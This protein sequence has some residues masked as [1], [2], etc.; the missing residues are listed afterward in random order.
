MKR[1]AAFLRSIVPADPAQLIF[2]AGVVLLFVS[3]RVSWWPSKLLHSSDFVVQTANRKS[4]LFELRQ[5]ITFALLPVTFAGVVGYFLCLWPAKK[6]V[7]LILWAL[8]LPSVFG[9]S[10]VMWKTFAIT[11]EFTSVLD[12]RGGF[13]GLLSWFH[14]NAGRFPAGPIIA[15]GGLLLILVFVVRLAQGTSSLPLVLPTSDPTSSQESEV[16]S[17]VRLLVF[18]LIGPYFLLSGWMALGLFLVVQRTSSSLAM[19][20]I[21]HS[22][23]VFEAALLIYLSLLVMG[24]LGRTS[25]RTAFQIPKRADIAVAVLLPV[26]ASCMVPAAHYVIDRVEWAAH[27][28]GKFLP[29]PQ[30]SLYFNPSDAWE[31]WLLLMV[32]A[33][34]AEELIF[35]GI[36]LRSFIDRYGLHRGIF[37][38]GMAWA[39][40]HF[41]SDTYAGL[42]PGG[43]GSP[44]E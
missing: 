41:R 3:T 17:R 18:V 29:P 35:R 25:I 13:A 30:V 23:F 20:V 43:S 9:F 44:S 24:R 27:S 1:V 5:L 16:W 32:F 37:L 40:I 38:T 28:Y 12:R 19:V 8:C 21:R 14:L 22:S 33:A 36:M 6:T 11:K 15:A 42:S 34:L 2:L 26:V 10:L 31:P 39:A 7:Q 4:I